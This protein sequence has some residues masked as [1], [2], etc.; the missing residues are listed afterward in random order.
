MKS[1]LAWEQLKQSEQKPGQPPAFEVHDPTETD[2]KNEFSFFLTSL[3]A[4][5]ESLDA[6]PKTVSENKK[7]VLK[8][9][10]L[11]LEQAVSALN[12]HRRFWNS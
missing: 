12:L 9:E 8:H 6:N 4:M 11:K 5:H 2:L 10:L 3:T 1:F 7:R